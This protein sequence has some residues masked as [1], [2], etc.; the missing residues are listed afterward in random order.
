[1][2]FRSL[3]ISFLFCFIAKSQLLSWAPEF[4]TEP[5]STV[6]IICDANFGNAGIKNYTPSTDI[7]VHIGA[8]TTASANNGDWKGSAFTWGTTNP[9]ANA[10]SIGTNKWKY[11]ITGGL[12]NFFNITNPSEK[13]LKIA[14]LFRTGSGT[15]VLR[16]TDGS[17]MFVP[18]YDNNFYTRID[19]PFRKPTFNL[20]V[21]TITKNVSD[22]ITITSKA[23][24]SSTIKLYFNN[25]LVSTTAAATQAT[26]NTTIVVSGTQTIVS[27][28]NNGTTT[29]Y[30][31]VK[32]FVASPVNIAALPSGV[33]DGI[34]Y[35]TDPTAVTLVL[36]APGKSNI[37]IIGDFNNWTETSPYQM[38][39]TADGNYFWKRLAGLTSGVEYAYQYVIDG[40]LK[41]ADY[42]CEKVLDPWNDQYISNT[43]YPS[44]KPY[45]TGLTSG[46][47]SV[48]QTNKPVYTWQNTF[49]RPDKKNLIIY[50]LLVRDFLNDKSYKT[51][52]DSLNYLKNL[53]INAIELMPIAEFEGNSSWG[54]N[55]SY[56]FAADKAYGTDIALKEFIDECHKNGIAVILDI[57]L[58]HSFGSN[59]MVQMYWDAASGKPAANSPWFNV[60]AKHDF[61]VGYDFNH[62]SQATKDFT[63]RVMRHWLTNYKV[64]GFRWDLSKGFTQTNSVGNIGL[65]GNYDAARIATWKRIYDTMQNISAN[66]YCI[67]E[68][69][70]NN[71]EETDLA[72][73]GMLLWGNANHNF[74][75]ASMGFTSESDFGSALSTS[76]S[77]SNAHLIGYAESHDEE[78]LMVKNISYGNVNGGY[79]I[80][81]TVT[82]LKR[83]EAV[84]A[85]LC[86]MPGPKMIWQ[87][88]ELGYDYSINYCPNGTTSTNCRVDDKPIKWNYLN[89][90]NRK[91]LYNVYSKLLRVRKIPAYNS[92]FTVSSV[93]ASLS[94][95]IK[96]IS[97]GDA[98]LRVV[99]VGNFGVSTTPSSVTFPFTGTWYDYLSNTSINVT[100]TSHGMLFQPGDY[101]VFTDK[102]VNA[103]LL[104][105]NPNP[106]V[107][108]VPEAVKDLKLSVGPNPINSNSIV[109][110][111]LPTS[112][113]VTLKMMDLNGKYI[114][115]LF[116][117]FQSKGKQQINFNKT[118][119]RVNSLLNGIYLI[120][121]ELNGNKQITKVVIAK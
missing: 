66:S 31:T 113:Q 79:N 103:V 16:N 111:E 119:A 68:H 30:D 107:S 81:D 56:F 102:N 46:I 29:V 65:W 48:L 1:M 95:A 104:N 10:V 73:Y 62:E 58:N 118:S 116:S 114:T 47:V 4:I 105:S 99:I 36:Y 22:N 59:P 25:N 12:R 26:S 33:K 18:V 34:N 67:L 63:N 94:S 109:N 6:E 88:G 3:L 80:K 28:A 96:Q 57:V 17:D 87:M 2:K 91:N 69:F 5:A 8:I 27:E 40:S 64:D 35:E 72:N 9:L 77:W 38:N 45:P 32:F 92:S 90:T 60:D 44:L 61:N 71:S 43:T 70:A 14:I 50:E 76:R 84:A 97:F 51:L 55:P 108:I 120:Q 115:N 106:T 11:T 21:E 110:Y 7:Y 112:G 74:N 15:S 54:Y 42:N 20:G 19:N 86:M 23:S 100:S 24:A 41:V 117:G 98:N 37:T 75:Q 78:R 83:Q 13:I 101:Y 53:G 85:F 52:K 49:T 82:A 93:S 39:R 89:N 121:V